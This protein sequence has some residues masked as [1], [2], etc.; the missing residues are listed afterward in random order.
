MLRLQSDGKAFNKSNFRR[1]LMPKLLNRSDK[2]I[3]FKHCNI[4]AVLIQLGRPYIIGYK[5]LWNYQNLL[6]DVV[7]ERLAEIDSIEDLLVEKDRVEKII[8][9]QNV[10]FDKWNVKPPA[11]R[12]LKDIP[13]TY[14][15]VKK[16]YFEIE[17]KSHAIGYSGEELV[18]KYEKWRLESQGKF[19]LSRRIEW[20]SQ[21]RG[22]GAG[23]DIL[24][25][26]FD[27]S[28]RFIEVKTT[29]YGKETPIFFS[30]RENDFSE[31]NSELFHLYRV[32]ELKQAPK[33]FQ[34]NGAFSEF[35]SSI[36]AN[37]FVG[38]F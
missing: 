14:R 8:R 27:G 2:S 32:F 17:Q 33:L 18:L 20:V 30:K 6:R 35:C 9:P 36:S 28:E 4:S 24:S 38:R 13:H 26:N 16:N 23:Y 3:D 37:S 10:S 22:D 31:E 29:A 12:I 34:F 15:A 11:P 5:P 21:E 7:I 25:R 19:S 1:D